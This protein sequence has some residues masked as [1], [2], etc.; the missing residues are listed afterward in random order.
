MGLKCA[1]QKTELVFMKRGNPQDP[2]IQQVYLTIEDQQVYRA[3]KLVRILGVQ[4]NNRWTHQINLL[5]EQLDQLGNMIWRVTNRHRGMRE[6]DIL[7]LVQSFAISPVV[8]VT[9][10][11]T[12]S[13]QSEEA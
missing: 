2:A 1:R 12:E 3:C 6:A 9:P 10:F 5:N 11:L 13:F 4:A 7:R 8:Y